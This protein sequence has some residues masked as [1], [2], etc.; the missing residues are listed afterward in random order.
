[1]AVEPTPDLA[2]VIEA[3]DFVSLQEMLKHWTPPTAAGA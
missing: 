3:R 1:M 2:R